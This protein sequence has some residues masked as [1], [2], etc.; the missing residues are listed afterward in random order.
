M[1]LVRRMDLFYGYRR[2]RSPALSVWYTAHR[3]RVFGTL[4]MTPERAHEPRCGI[5][6]LPRFFPDFC[7][8]HVPI[9]MAKNEI[10]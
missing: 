6:A 5:C 8:F 10:R 9:S 3:A 4:F 7:S 2:A 1:R